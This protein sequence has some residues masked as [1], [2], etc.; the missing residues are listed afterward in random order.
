MPSRKKH[1][2][3]FDEFKYENLIEATRA[4]STFLAFCETDDEWDTVMR[5]FYRIRDE[6]H[7]MSH[8]KHTGSNTPKEKT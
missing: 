3:A 8:E 4:Y 2:Q 6:E 1:P 7:K 5:L